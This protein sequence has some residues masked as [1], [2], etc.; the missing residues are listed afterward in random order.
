MADMQQAFY[1]TMKSGM[2]AAMNFRSAKFGRDESGRKLWKGVKV[3]G[4]KR[5]G[6]KFLLL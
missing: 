4:E 6:V 1:E 3:Q 5:E 2:F